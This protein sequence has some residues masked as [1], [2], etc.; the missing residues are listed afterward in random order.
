MA[1]AGETV[2]VE[3]LVGR[4]YSKAAIERFGAHAVASAR[5]RS[6]RQIAS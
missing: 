6:V 3:T 4:G 1:F 5:R 2:S